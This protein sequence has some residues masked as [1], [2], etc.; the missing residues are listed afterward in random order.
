MT[1]ILV[2]VPVIRHAAGFQPFSAGAG[3][4]DVRLSPLLVAHF[5][6]NWHLGTGIMIKQLVGDAADSPVVD[7][8]G[9]ATQ[10]LVGASLL[11]S[12]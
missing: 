10:I 2:S 9:S 12:W 3:F 8:R 5:S 11:Y 7:D 6:R 4:K 1:P